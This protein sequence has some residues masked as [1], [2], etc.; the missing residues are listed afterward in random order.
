MFTSLSKKFIEAFK[1]SFFYF[2]LFFCGFFEVFVFLVKQQVFGHQLPGYSAVATDLLYRG[3]QPSFRGVKELMDKG[4]RT[5]IN[6][7]KI[8]IL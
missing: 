8:V 1:K 7:P 6:L 2:L 3:G 5:I 4:F